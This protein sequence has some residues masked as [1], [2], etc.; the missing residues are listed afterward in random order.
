MRVERLREKEKKKTSSSSIP[1]LSLPSLLPSLSR[2]RARNPAAAQKNTRKK[3]EQKKKVERKETSRGRGQAKK[4]KA[5][6]SSSSVFLSLLRFHREKRLVPLFSNLATEPPRARTLRS[7]RPRGTRNK[8]ASKR[9]AKKTKKKKHQ[10]ETIGHDDFRSMGGGFD[11]SSLSSLLSS[12]FLKSLTPSCTA[13]IALSSAS[14]ASP[15]RRR[16]FSIVGIW[17]F[18]FLKEMK[19]EKRKKIDASSLAA[20]FR[21]E[22]KE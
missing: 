1:S 5:S 9:R 11:A 22:N 19:D 17:F 10:K 20:V 6:S 7:A 8:R 14:M 4:K 18:F 13:P 21:D 3:R 15:W 12:L 16:W 2:R